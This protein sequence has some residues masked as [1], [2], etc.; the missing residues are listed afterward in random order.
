MTTYRNPAAW[1]IM[2]LFIGGT[3][4]GAQEPAKQD[5]KKTESPPLHRLLPAEIADQLKLDEEQQKKIQQLEKE[6]KSKRDFAMMQTM[7]K[8]KNVMDSIE[9]EGEK[10]A[11]ALAVT[12]AITGTLLEMRRT[13]TAYES[14]LLGVLDDQQK[15]QYQELTKS[16]KKKKR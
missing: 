7:L 9:K 5:E 3:T 15:K 13:Q 1:A 11:A 10:G 12:N 16:K 6:F 14:K 2:L 8:M 4:A